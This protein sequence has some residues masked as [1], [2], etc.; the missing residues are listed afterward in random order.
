[1]AVFFDVPPWEQNSRYTKY[2]IVPPVEDVVNSSR[3]LTERKLFNIADV[4]W[5]FERTGHTSFFIFDTY[6]QILL[7]VFCWI[8]LLIGYCINKN[9]PLD[10]KKYMGKY[11]SFLHKVHE[12]C[13]FYVGIN[14]VLEWMYFEST[15]LERW[16]SLGS[17]ILATVYFLVY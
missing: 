15:S 14:T 6:L 11:Y 12:I 17:C 9:K 5:R 13:I 10:F 4:E 16:L 1:M 8:L 2:V 7:I 3:L